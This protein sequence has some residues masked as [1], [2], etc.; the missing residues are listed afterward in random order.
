MII[1]LVIDW[2]ACKYLASFGIALAMVI[3][4][5]RATPWVFFVFWRYCDDV[6]YVKQDNLKI[7]AYIWYAFGNLY[8]EIFP[9]DKI[10]ISLYNIISRPPTYVLRKGQ[11][12]IWKWLL[13]PYLV[14]IMSTLQITKIVNPTI[15]SG[16]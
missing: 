1:F 11:T 16:L 2:L 10:Y 4:M 3:L 6:C 15:I 12:A 8:L 7:W 5:D 14:L 13:V 9:E